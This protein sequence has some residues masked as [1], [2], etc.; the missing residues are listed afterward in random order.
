MPTGPGEALSSVS[1]K[2]RNYARKQGAVAKKQC[3]ASEKKPHG[4]GGKRKNEPAGLPSRH[5]E[6][7]KRPGERLNGAGEG[8]LSLPLTRQPVLR[9]P[10]LIG[11][12]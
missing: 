7:P 11:E 5:V 3:A 12:T 6:K 4:A 9:G 1:G 8:T 2:E 10:D